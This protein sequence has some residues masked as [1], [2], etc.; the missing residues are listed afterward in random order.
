M[1]ESPT[2]SVSKRQPAK[3]QSIYMHHIQPG[4]VTAKE[5]MLCW[6]AG[7]MVNGAARPVFH[8][9]VFSHISENINLNAPTFGVDAF[10]S[11]P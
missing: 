9:H 4:T 10:G 1:I 3:E 11:T 5:V 7:M 2:K 8:E 6:N